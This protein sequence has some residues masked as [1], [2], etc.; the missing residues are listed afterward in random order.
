LPD[1]DAHART[2]RSPRAWGA[3]LGPLRPGDAAPLLSGVQVAHDR[4]DAAM[5][6]G[7]DVEAERSV[8]V[9]DVLDDGLLGQHELL[10]DPRI[11]ASLRHEAE[12][13]ALARGEFAE[14]ARAPAADHAAHDLGVE[15]RGPGADAA[16]VRAERV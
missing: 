7:V 6:V 1:D 15:D 14:G 11:A 5:V 2:L 16:Q 12:H 3:D 10:G 8:D 9:G 13:V 4:E